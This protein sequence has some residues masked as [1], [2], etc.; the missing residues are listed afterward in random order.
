MGGFSFQAVNSSDK[1]IPDTPPQESQE[2]PSPTNK[3]NMLQKFVTGSL[4]T[5]VLI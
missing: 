4:L 1:I 5:I 2:T 3:D